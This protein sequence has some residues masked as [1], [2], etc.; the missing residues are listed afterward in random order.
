MNINHLASKDIS[1]LNQPGLYEIENVQN[2]KRYIGQTENLLERLGK[3]VSTL[4]DKKHDC[5]A[6][7]KDWNESPEPAKN[8]VFRVISAGPEWINKGKREQ[9][10]GCLIEKIEV[11]FLYNQLRQ[12][13]RLEP[14]DENYRVILT[15][16]GTTYNSMAEATKALS[17]PET[18]LRRYLNDEANTN[19]VIVARVKHGYSPVVVDDKEYDSLKSVEKALKISR[20]TVHK[21]L[22]SPE[23]PRWSYKKEPQ[24]GK[25]SRSQNNEKQETE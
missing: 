25:G 6:L 14:L 16:N 8:F 11:S 18:T 21:R 20:S 10:E 12:K 7:Q 9:E 15:A 17:I 22:N 3:H 19:F 4:N 24:K 2:T 1:W 13:K 23:W 5:L